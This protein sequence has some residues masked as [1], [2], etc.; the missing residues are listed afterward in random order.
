MAVKMTKKNSKNH[1]QETENNIVCNISST[2]VINKSNV[3]TSAALGANHVQKNIKTI[4]QMHQNTWQDLSGGE[5]EQH[6]KLHLCSM[7]TNCCIPH[8]VES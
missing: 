8:V 1:Y 2:H 3:S 5:Q 4:N 7:P 6:T